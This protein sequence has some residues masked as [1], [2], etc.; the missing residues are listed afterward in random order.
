MRPEAGVRQRGLL[1]RRIVFADSERVAGYVFPF[2]DR[3][4][5]VPFFVANLGMGLPM[6]LYGPLRMDRFRLPDRAP[7]QR[8]ATNRIGPARGTQP[9]RALRSLVGSSETPPL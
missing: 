7:E 8:V 5:R 6:V 2:V 3:R 1:D 9:A 4:W